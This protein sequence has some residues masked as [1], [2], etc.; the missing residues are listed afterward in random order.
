MRKQ[1]SKRNTNACLVRGIR[2]A[3]AS[4]GADGRNGVDVLSSALLML[5]LLMLMV[6]LLLLRGR[7]LL[8]GRHCFLFLGRRARMLLRRAGVLGAHH[9]LALLLLVWRVLHALKERVKRA[10]V[11]LTAPRL[12]R[13]ST[14]TAAAAAAGGVVQ[15]LVQ[16]VVVQRRARVARGPAGARRA[17]LAKAAQQVLQVGRGVA[18]HLAHRLPLFLVV[19]VPRLRVGQARQT[20][21]GKKKTRSNTHRG[22]QRRHVILRVKVVVRH[23]GSEPSKRRV[24]FENA[25]RTG[26]ARGGARRIGLGAGAGG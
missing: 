20:R 6:L 9:H 26:L 10:S 18:A 11:L 25:L 8:L 17:L 12:L 2:G 5:L 1:Q 16:R 4:V 19:V 13:E 15:E 3:E 7:L 23:G 14:P 22:R 24:N 21:D